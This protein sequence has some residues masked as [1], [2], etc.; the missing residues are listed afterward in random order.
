MT[1]AD[2]DRDGS[3]NAARP[4]HKQREL[5]AMR[6]FGIAKVAEGRIAV[7][8]SVTSGI[9]SCV[10]LVCCDSNPKLDL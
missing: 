10:P 7:C 4:Q 5:S 3:Q 2:S 8:V 6:G 1:L 9:Q